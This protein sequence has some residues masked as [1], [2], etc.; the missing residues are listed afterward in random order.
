VEFQG[1]HNFGHIM[2]NRLPGPLCTSRLG[3]EWNN[4]ATMGRQR[5][6]APLVLGHGS[7]LFDPFDQHFRVIDFRSGQ[8]ITNTPYRI[9]LSD[10]KEFRGL[11]DV[12]AH[13]VIVGADR[14][15]TA[16]LEIPYHGNNSS[17]VD[18]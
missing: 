5:T 18:P 2:P 16:K 1:Q 14:V 6:S 8:P 4:D 3:T 13:T 10:G 12:F 17:S 7:A 11:T 9:W 15:Q